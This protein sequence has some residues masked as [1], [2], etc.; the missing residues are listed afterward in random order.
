MQLYTQEFYK[1]VVKQKLNPGGIFVTQSGPAGVLS[2]SQVSH[3]RVP[4]E[5]LRQVN[6]TAAVSEPTLKAKTCICVLCTCCAQE[7]LP[8]VCLVVQVF[9]AINH[10]LASVFPTVV[11]YAQHLPSFADCWVR[12]CRVPTPPAVD[13]IQHAKSCM[14]SCTK[15]T[16]T[17][18]V[19]ECHVNCQAVLR[20]RPGG[21]S[22]I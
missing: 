10:T 4:A 22:S 1:T 12:C 3:P 5:N 19:V 8:Y 14:S 11:P 6:S 21:S 18:L 20:L 16:V 9:S 17:L 7:L 13:P 15:I 2:A